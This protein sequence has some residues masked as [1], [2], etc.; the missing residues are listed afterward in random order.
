[1]AKYVKVGT[2]MNGKFGNFVALGNSK[3]NNE[4]YRFTTELVV[5]DSSGKVL[6][7]TTNGLLMVQDP[8]TR[9]GITEDQLDKIPDNVFRELVLKI[10]E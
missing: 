4:K 7:K 3:A 5:T 2:I 1:M 10:E 8:R 6:G 9:P